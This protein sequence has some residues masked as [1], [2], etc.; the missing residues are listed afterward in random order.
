MT[1]NSIT[2]LLMVTVLLVLAIPVVASAQYHNR[3]RYARDNRP[4]VREVLSS[5]DNSSA[6]LE[7]DLKVPRERRASRAFWAGNSESVGI[8]EVR[9]FRRAVRRLK[10]VSNAGRE[11]RS[12]RD[13][14]R[15]VVNRGVQLDR[16][17]RLRTGKTTVDADL[18]E[19]RSSLHLIADAYGL[20]IPY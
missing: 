8:A 6:R 12:S 7:R 15:M 5:L 13:E 4:D 14:A 20:R 1:N 18:S 10:D 17:L 19:I 16:Y 11:L 3:N 2:R 9:D